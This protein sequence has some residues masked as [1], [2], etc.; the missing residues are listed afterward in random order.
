[1]L[2]KNFIAILASL[3]TLTLVIIACKSPTAS[4]PGTPFARSLPI[5]GYSSTVDG[6]TKASNI[7]DTL[8]LRVNSLSQGD[9]LDSVLVDWGDSTAPTSITDS[10]KLSMFIIGQDNMLRHWYVRADSSLNPFTCYTHARA[11]TVKGVVVGDTLIK[12]KV[13]KKTE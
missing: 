6:V 12:C 8:Y 3:F 13:M 9:T 7:F 4:V 10:L 5:P 2:K 1:M 11:V